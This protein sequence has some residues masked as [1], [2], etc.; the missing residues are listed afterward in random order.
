M[1]RAPCPRP[2]VD[3]ITHHNPARQEP[4]FSHFTKETKAGPGREAEGA[5]DFFHIP[6]VPSMGGLRGWSLTADVLPTAVPWSSHILILRTVCLVLGRAPSSGDK[7]LVRDR[8][9]SELL[10][11][12]SLTAA[13]SPSRMNRCGGTSRE[14]QTEGESLVPPPAPPSPRWI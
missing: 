9:V 4:S 6:G 8:Q 5:L 11:K 3:Y 12:A 10:Q 1:S 14:A 7:E 2:H 13:P